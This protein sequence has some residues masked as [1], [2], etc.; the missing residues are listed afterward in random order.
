MQNGMQLSGDNVKN[1]KDKKEKAK[2]NALA[3]INVI[4]VSF[5]IFRTGSV[6]IV[7]M[8]EENV[9]NDIYAFLTQML[10]TEFEHICQ[11]LIT[12][13][14][15]KDKKKKVRRKVIMIMTTLEPLNAN[16]SEKEKEKEK[17][18]AV[19][20]N[21]SNSNSNSKKEEEIPEKKVK[22]SYNKKK[23]TL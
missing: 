1:M 19:S 22:R 20:Y 4:E 8:C 15:L 9:L 12:S 23:P 2:A 14:M 10:K 16:S 11:S 7:G 21:H 17:L 18:E 6:L 13:S 5:M 3:N